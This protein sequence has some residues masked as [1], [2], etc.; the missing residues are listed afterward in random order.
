M[1]LGLAVLGGCSL[2]KVTLTAK[3]W[4]CPVGTKEIACT[5]RNG[6]LKEISFGAFFRLETRAG[7]EWIEM[8]PVNEL[9]FVT[10]GYGL[11]PAG[12]MERTYKTGHYYGPLPAGQYRIAA[13]YSVKA[14][15]A[16]AEDCPAYAEFEVK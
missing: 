5:W 16:N 15:A 8:E 11:W 9:I 3:E 13:E 7:G 4:T 12:R 6:T 1:L 2:G 10:I 14:G